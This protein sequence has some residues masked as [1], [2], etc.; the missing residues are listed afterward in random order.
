MASKYGKH[1]VLA[2]ILQE[3]SKYIL[4][5]FGHAQNCP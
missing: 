2:F 1:D 5:Y 4:S 3:H